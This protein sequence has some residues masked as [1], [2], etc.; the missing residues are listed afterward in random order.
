MVTDLTC[1]LHR[2]LEDGGYAAEGDDLFGIAYEALPSARAWPT[3]V[4]LRIV[5]RWMGGVRSWVAD[6]AVWVSFVA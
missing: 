4:R 5:A 2:V 3:E 6:G 1:L